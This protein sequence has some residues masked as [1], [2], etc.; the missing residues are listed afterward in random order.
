[1]NDTP[2]DHSHAVALF[3][4]GVIADLVQLPPGTK[5][6]YALI[7]QKAGRQYT[8]PGSPRT[9][10]APETIRDW[11]KRY[12]RGG[13]DALLPK[14]RAD[15][16]RSRAL[17]PQVA[18]LLLGI[19][20]GNPKLSVQLVIREARGSKEVPP[21]L[22]LPPA[23][24]H[25]LLARHGLMDKPKGEPIDADRRRFAFK[26]AGELWMSD[27]MHGPTVFIGGRKRKTYLI[28][29]I[30]DATRVIP[31]CAFTLSENTTTFL[32]V[33][34]QAVQR[35]GLPKRLYVD[36]G[37]NYRSRHLAIVCAKLG[38]ALIHARPYRPQGKDYVSH[39]TSFV[40]FGST[41]GKRRRCT[42]LRPWALTGG[43]SPGCSYRHS[44][45]SL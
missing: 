15:R 21:E 33:L 24:V 35:R 32:P 2:S 27:V 18:D 41:W 7:D 28:A 14:S 31:D 40:R 16:G 4:Y 22:P 17:P 38:V 12:R 36:N 19:K 34:K 13:F 44:P 26:R 5:G 10:V 37:A 42:S 29:F 6:L 43:S 11:L 9:R 8:I 23:T 39:C 30:D 25:R 20:E 3:R 45:L 1:M